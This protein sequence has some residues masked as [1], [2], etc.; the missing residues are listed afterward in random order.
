MR[1]H[2]APITTPSGLGRA[3]PCLA[4]QAELQ[5]RLDAEKP[6]NHVDLRHRLDKHGKRYGKV[7]EYK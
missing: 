3:I 2:A 5:R 4:P 6:R 7:I 1:G